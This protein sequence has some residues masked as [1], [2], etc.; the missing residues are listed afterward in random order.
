MESDILSGAE[1]GFW[2]TLDKSLQAYVVVR[3][4]EN[5]L[6]VLNAVELSECERQTGFEAQTVKERVVEIKPAIRGVFKWTVADGWQKV[7]LEGR[8]SHHLVKGRTSEGAGEF[9]SGTSTVPNLPVKV[10]DDY[11]VPEGTQAIL[12]LGGDSLKQLQD[13]KILAKDRTITSYRTIPH[14][15]GSVPVSSATVLTLATLTT[16]ITWTC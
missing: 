2:V 7:Q 6:F 10:V 11:S 3:E 1:V 13:E 14:M 8:C 15:R 16:V 12:A 4:K 9:V 5:W